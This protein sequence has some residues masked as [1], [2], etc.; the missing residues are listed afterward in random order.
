MAPV[1]WMEPIPFGW[2]IQP[3]GIVQARMPQSALLL[4]DSFSQAGELTATVTVHRAA[5][6]PTYWKTVGIALWL[7][8]RNFWRLNL[9]EAPDNLNRQHSAELHE[10]YQGTWLAGNEPATRLTVR[11]DLDYTRPGWV[12]EF[13]KPSRSTAGILGLPVVDVQL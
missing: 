6:N 4:E 5:D 13:G 9:V 3:D 7:H 8:E 10:M 11:A 2:T 12:W 1:Q